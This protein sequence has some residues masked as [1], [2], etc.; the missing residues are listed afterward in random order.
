VVGWP[1][2]DSVYRGR[3]TGRVEPG[4]AAV[5]RELAFYGWG[6]GRRS[7]LPPAPSSAALLALA[8]AS[9]WRHYLHG[10]I[11]SSWL[12]KITSCPQPSDPARQVLPVLIPLESSADRFAGRPVVWQSGRP[13]PPGSSATPQ[14]PAGVGHWILVHPDRHLFCPTRPC[15]TASGPRSQSFGRD[16]LLAFTS[17]RRRPIDRHAAGV[18]PVS[19][20]PASSCSV[21]PRSAVVPVHGVAPTGDRVIAARP[22]RRNRSRRVAPTCVGSRSAKLTGSGLGPLRRPRSRR[23]LGRVAP[24]RQLSGGAPSVGRPSG[25]RPLGPPGVRGSFTSV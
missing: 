11:R 21:V 15:G 17:R 2:M 3:S 6:S 19:R 25:T 4:P 22:P 18:G 12:P 1:Q 14:A 20:Q 7:A 8:Y 16:A 9:A 10:S 5:E 24:G 13:A 23:A